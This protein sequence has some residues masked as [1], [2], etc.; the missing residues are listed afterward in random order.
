MSESRVELDGEVIITTA[1]GQRYA[2]TFPFAPFLTCL[3]CGALID[4]QLTGRH[5]QMPGHEE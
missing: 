2:Q 5:D 4:Q 1:P 3:I